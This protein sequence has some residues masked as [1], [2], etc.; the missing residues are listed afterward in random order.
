[1]LHTA[2]PHWV[3]ANRRLNPAQSQ[4]DSGGEISDSLSLDSVFSVYQLV[5]LGSFPLEL[6]MISAES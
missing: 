1:M 5:E 6:K 4:V 2:I 3:T